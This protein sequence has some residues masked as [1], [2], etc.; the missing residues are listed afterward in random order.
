MALTFCVQV[1][2][3]A[4]VDVVSLPG[5]SA[6]VATCRT[7]LSTVEATLPACTWASAWIW[8][9]AWGF[10]SLTP[11]LP[12]AP[13]TALCSDLGRDPAAARP[14]V[15][16][17]AATTPMM[18]TLAVMDP[19]KMLPNTSRFLHRGLRPRSPPGSP[20]GAEVGA[21]GLPL[22]SAGLPV[23]LASMPVGTSGLAVVPACGDG[24]VR[25]ALSWADA[26]ICERWSCR[27]AGDGWVTDRA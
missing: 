10:G 8:A 7:R 20:V 1:W 19:P 6:A 21:P 22:A 3:D 15:A 16:A 5:C 9:V 4:T 2:V 23:G 26:T 13:A 27:V 18:A 24:C 17:V 12:A 11:T 14:P 25:L